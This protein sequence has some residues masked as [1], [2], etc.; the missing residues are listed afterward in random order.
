VLMQG[1]DDPDAGKTKRG[2]EDPDVEVRG[3]NSLPLSNDGLYVG[4]PR[5]PVPAR[6]AE[7]VV[8]RRRICSGA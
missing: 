3:P 7:A 5:Q 2:S 4:P 6:I 8:M 1:N